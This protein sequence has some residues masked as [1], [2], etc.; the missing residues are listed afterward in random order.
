MINKILIKNFKGIK[1]SCI[2][3]LDQPKNIF[4][5][6][7]E[8]GKSTIL[9]AINLALTKR[10][11]GL[12]IDFG[13]NPYIFNIEEVLRFY[14]KLENLES[15]NHSTMPYILI[16]IYFKNNTIY[17]FTEGSNNSLQENSCGISL[18]IKF[19]EEYIQEFS[20]IYKQS[21]LNSDKVK[22]VP[23]EFY[24]Y[25]WKYFNGQ[26]VTNKT[27][28]FKVNF[29]DD[30]RKYN[31]NTTEKLT[32]QY[33]NQFLNKIEKAKLTSSYNK[34]KQSFN[35]HEILNELNNKLEE[36]KEYTEKNMSIKLDMSPQFNWEGNMIPYLDDIPYTFIGK[37]E[38]NIINTL[39]AVKSF[40]DNQAY[41]NITLLEE[42]ENH[43]SFSK[44]YRMLHLIDGSISKDSQI[45]ITSHSSN[46]INRLGLNY[47]FLLQKNSLNPVSFKSLNQGDIDFFKKTTGFD[48]LRV[49]LSEKIVL[50]EGPAD[51]LIFNRAFFDIKN[52][53]RHESEIDVFSVNGTSFKRY[54]ALKKIAMGSS[55]EIKKQDSKV[56]VITDN[57]GQFEKKF[58]DRFSEYRDICNLF[59]EPNNNL[60]TLE[61]SFIEVN[62]DKLNQIKTLFNPRNSENITKLDLIKWMKDNKTKWALAVH[63]SEVQFNYPK[64]IVNAINTL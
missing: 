12:G 41:F 15:W 21:D 13:L 32:N 39:L 18:K 64:N 16:E 20:E 2:V 35:N 62:I 33:S 11:L 55:Q 23:H 10:H 49:I 28:S 37:G 48:T 6:N 47:T 25:E 4:V 45:F 46:I 34:F 9:E 26:T 19:N 27:M 31:F 24:N 38:Q 60:N 22:F 54:L 58:N 29:I 7:N 51:E 42:P 57:D 30:S 5:G 53:Y 63:D 36:L 1:N 17:Q 3:N 50:V 52:K 59:I 43:L 56:L 40:S 44:M 8:A 61:P 14:H